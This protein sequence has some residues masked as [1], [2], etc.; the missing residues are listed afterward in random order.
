MDRY[1]S[2][3]PVLG[4]IQQLKKFFLDKKTSASCF[5]NAQVTEPGIR[6]ALKMRV[7]RV[8]VPPWVPTS[9]RSSTG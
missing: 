5:I 9:A 8:R 4:C 7:L 6:T 3:E 1:H 2:E